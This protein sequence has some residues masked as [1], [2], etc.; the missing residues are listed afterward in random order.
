[1]RS[2]ELLDYAGYVSVS[3]ECTVDSLMK[4]GLRILVLILAGFSASFAA[5]YFW[6]TRPKAPPGMVWITGGDFIMGTDAST[7]W[8]EESPAHQVRVSGFWID[9]TEV[10]NAQFRRFVDATGYI[11][12]AEK[13]PVLEELMKQLP[14]GT[15]PPDPSVLVPG[16]LVFT[17]PD[18]PVDLRDF[19][20]WW[21]WVPGADWKHPHGPESDLNGKENH[22]VVHVSWDDATAY[23]K[24]AGKRLPTEAEWER[25]ARG[26]LNGKTYI[27]GEDDPTDENPLANIWQGDFPH[28][29]SKADKYAGT[30]P[31]KSFPANKF[32]LF[33]M[34]GNVWEWCSDWYDHELYEKRTGKEVTINPSGPA[35]TN[36]PSR[37]YEP[38]RV[39]RG[40]SFLCNDSYCSRYRPMPPDMDVR[41]TPGCHTSA[42]GAS[43]RR[44]CSNNNQ[45]PKSENNERNDIEDMRTTL[46]YFF[47]TITCLLFVP[48]VIRA[49]PSV[50]GQQIIQVAQSENAD[51]SQSR[52]PSPSDQSVI[53]TD[54]FR[55]SATTG[56][57]SRMIAGS[58][59]QQPTRDIHSLSSCRDRRQH[60]SLSAGKRRMA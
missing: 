50:G 3:K 30:S 29:N 37:P 39:Q 36:N 58:S 17:P 20:Q 7:G 43:S 9:E 34:S 12:T 59:R 54:A 42:F 4:N 40:G 11:T 32:G 19:S 47:C 28:E 57:R 48:L 51:T 14:P 56:T 24:W 5:T 23:A 60:S 41:L 18:G 1:M 55:D 35:Q 10:T 16:S 2:E 45:K 21:S 53:E 8:P 13:P 27:W 22:P 38:Q 26:G 49:E 25:A 46:D 33:D 6:K 44:P 15:P 31:V 52:R